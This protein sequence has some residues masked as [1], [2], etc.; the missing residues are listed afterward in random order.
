M[1][2][3]SNSQDGGPARNG[4][5]TPTIVAIGASAGGIQALQKLMSALP[6]HTGAA[7]VVI[8]HLDPQRRSD[9]PRILASRTSM[10]VVQVEGTEKIEADHIY[11]IPPDRRL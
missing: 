2:M 10:T 7:F 3:E 11:V 8:V 9:L 6:D 5:D 4:N 1:A